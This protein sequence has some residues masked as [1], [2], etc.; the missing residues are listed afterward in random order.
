MIDLPYFPIYVSDLLGSPT[1]SRMSLTEQGAYFRLLLFGWAMDG[2]P[3]DIPE[4]AR[5]LGVDPNSHVNSDVNSPV[6]S[7]LISRVI[8]LAWSVD[9]SDPTRLRNDR[10]EVERRKAVTAYTRK[11]AALAKAR[12]KNPNN[13]P[14]SS[15]KALPLQSPE[16]GSV[17]SPV[18]EPVQGAELV[19]EHKLR[20][21]VTTQHSARVTAWLAMVEEKAPGFV[22]DFAK[23]FDDSPDPDGLWREYDGRLGGLNAPMGKAIPLHLLGQATR[24]IHQRGQKVTGLILN[25]FLRPLLIGRTFGEDPEPPFTP[26]GAP[27]V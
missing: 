23:A 14:K 3:N 26:I 11:C 18:Q 17:Q 9:P 21:Q 1:V 22:G 27:N 24:D 5:L 8:T 13:H 25:H 7:A 15:G 16:Q 2:I 12:L 20:T 19:G 10:Q 4:I 6:Y